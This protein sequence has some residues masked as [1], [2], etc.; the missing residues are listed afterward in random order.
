LKPRVSFRRHDSS[1][2]K[3]AA[4]NYLTPSF[5]TFNRNE[6]IFYSEYSYLFESYLLGNFVLSQLKEEISSQ[7][8]RFHKAETTNNI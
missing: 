7:K 1:K 4:V 6:N 3:L 8:K 2:V 5:S